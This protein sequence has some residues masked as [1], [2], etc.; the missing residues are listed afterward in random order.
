MKSVRTHFGVII[1]LIGLLFSIQFSFFVNTLVNEYEKI[2]KDEY[3]IILVSKKALD[4]NSLKLDEIQNLNEISSKNMLES[5]Q[6]KVSK[7][8]IA[9]VSQNLPKFYSVSLKFF[10]SNEQLEFIH[11]KLQKID[12]VSRVEIFSKSHS[13]IYKLLL[14][15][16][17]LVFSFSVLVAILGVMLMLKQMKIW[18][19][20]HKNRIEV[21]NLFG[22]QYLTKSIF[23]YKLAFWDSL[24]AAIL[25]SGF[26]FILPNFAIYKSF[27]STI[28]LPLTY[29][30]TIDQILFIFAMSLSVAFVSATF[31]MFGIKEENL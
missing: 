31:V 8:A 30:L 6:N 3:S 5:L 11:Q 7:E 19:F 26:F 20:E 2:I 22:A 1:S 28:A 25:V 27:I 15:I 29:T 21:M 17:S 23:L 10:P 16:K 12:G 9:K 14:F 18:T 24:I 13:S 4:L